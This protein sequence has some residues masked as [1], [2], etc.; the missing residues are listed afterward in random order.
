MHE[1]M[2]AAEWDAL[3]PIL[4]AEQ[5]A[6]VVGVKPA[7]VQRWAT[8]GDFPGVKVGKVWRFAKSALAGDRDGGVGPAGPPDRP[9]RR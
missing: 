3:P 4:T 1:H 8:A 2:T 5:V 9:G 6:R 7:Q